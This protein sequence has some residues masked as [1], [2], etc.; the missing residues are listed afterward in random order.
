[1]T[2]VP[3]DGPARP[4]DNAAAEVTVL[5]L[6]F[7]AGTLHLLRAAVRAR[8]AAAGIPPNPVPVM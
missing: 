6:P 2:E 5:D 3:L 8:A 7:D 4:A 1:M